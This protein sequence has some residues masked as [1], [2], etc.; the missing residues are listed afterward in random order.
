MRTYIYFHKIW[1]RPAKESQYFVAVAHW[2]T[3][4]WEIVSCS[5]NCPPRDWSTLSPRRGQ[6]FL[7]R[8]HVYSLWRSHSNTVVFSWQ[9]CLPVVANIGQIGNRRFSK[10][11]W[12]ALWYHRALGG[13]RRQGG[14]RL[15]LLRPVLDLD[16]ELADEL[17]EEVRVAVLAQLV[18]HKPVAELEAKNISC[19]YSSKCR[20]W[21][22]RH[23]QLLKYYS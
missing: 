2:S 8:H 1:S 22:V 3:L 10:L 4:W 15:G 21:N 9:G 19:M 5:L 23:Q 20:N 18:Q 12:R 16:G 6:T 7:V 11:W 17:P 13:C 14:S